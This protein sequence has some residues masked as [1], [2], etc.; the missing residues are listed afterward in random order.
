M[1]LLRLALVGAANGGEMVH[2]ELNS[3][4]QQK[5]FQQQSLVLALIL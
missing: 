1:D 3:L 5:K 4:Q 2:L